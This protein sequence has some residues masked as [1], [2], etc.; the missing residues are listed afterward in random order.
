MFWTASA[1][2]QLSS[3]CSGIQIILQKHMGWKQ[4]VCV[5]SPVLLYLFYP[6]VVRLVQQFHR[7]IFLGF[8]AAWLKEGRKGK[9]RCFLSANCF[10]LLFFL[11]P[12]QRSAASQLHA[13]ICPI[14]PERQSRTILSV[15][16]PHGGP[17]RASRWIGFPSL[18]A[19][20]AAVCG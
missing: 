3:C 20:A 12:V 8:F 1:A 14:R 5:F 15:I 4:L 13:S 16:R 7:L 17:A 10:K 2:H 18:I 19:E 9:V 6:I 11:L